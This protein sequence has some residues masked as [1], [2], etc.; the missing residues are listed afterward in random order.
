MNKKLISIDIV[1]TWKLPIT[2][3]KITKISYQN[4]NVS[5]DIIY[6][7]TT[8]KIKNHQINISIFQQILPTPVQYQKDLIKISKVIFKSIIYP[9]YTC[10]GGELQVIW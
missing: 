5:T 4:R 3:F 9:D 7:Q 1:Y 6:T 10:Q 2:L 8:S